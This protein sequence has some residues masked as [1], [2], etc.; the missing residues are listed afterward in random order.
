MKNAGITKIQITSPDGEKFTFKLTDVLLDFESGIRE[1]ESKDGI[2]REFERDG[3]IS[4]RIKGKKVP[5]P[6][7][8]PNSK[9]HHSKSRPS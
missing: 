9:L 6:F 8:F 7:S 4:I 2:H 5:M 1:M 3:H